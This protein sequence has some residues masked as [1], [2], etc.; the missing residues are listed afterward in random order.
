MNDS[1]ILAYDFGTGGIK[2]SL[3]DG[4][5]VC[6]ASGFDAY[7]TH[8]PASGFH[9]QAPA[10]WWRAT[11]RSTRL[12]AEKAGDE[13]MS[14]VRAIGISGHSLGVVP[15][16]AAG[17][18]LRERV[19]I[20]SDSRAD[21][22]A[23]EFFRSIDETRWYETTGC[24]FPPGLY[25]V[26][27][28]MWFRK[29]EPEWFARVEVVLG[30]KDYINY[31]LT[32]IKAT[33]NSYASGSGVYSLADRAY[34]PALLDASG[35]PPEIFPKIVPSTYMLGTLTADAAK[36]LGL[37]QSTVV[38]AGGVDNSCMALGAGAYKEG[39]A[40]NSLG[41]SSW[42]AVS[43]AKPVIDAATRPYVFDHVVPGQYASALAIFS[44][45][46]SH[47]WLRDV[48]RLDYAEMDTLAE[49]AGRGAHGLFFNPSLAGGSSLDATPKIRGAFANLDLC[50]TS[51]DL[52]RAVMEGVAFGLRGALD[53]LRALVPVAEPL[54]L[55]GG[56]AK[57]AIWRQIYADVYGLRVVRTEIGQQAAALGA[58]AVAGVGCGLWPDFDIVDRVTRVTD[59]ETPTP[60]ART[61]YNRLY[62]RYQSL[63]AHLAEW[64]K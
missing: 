21:A 14:C 33:D 54:T 31:R 4:N 18:L 26:F 17:N 46:T 2:A 64:A 36:E 13:A 7:E 10:D 51:G 19:P 1:K 30:T 12:L 43:S 27:K 63:T 60:E 28:L 56:G 29:H 44:A 58:A 42:I 6:E 45:G 34:A 20:W 47:T 53:G 55:V 25:S 22:E 16:D 40:Y 9:E 41:S 37:P 39:R 15:L 11:V 8:Y 24:G 3:F 62:A 49:K 38:V 32:G 52:I 59:E 48:L 5:G 61:E 35:L 57:A 23:R 50:H